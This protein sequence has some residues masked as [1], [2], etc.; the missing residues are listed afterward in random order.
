MHL[1]GFTG[2]IGIPTFELWLEFWT[3]GTQN[4]GPAFGTRG[5]HNASV[6]TVLRQ[7]TGTL[8]L[9]GLLAYGKHQPQQPAS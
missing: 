5:T 3:P 8:G 1:P 9:F 7:Y 6:Q 2:C 4:P